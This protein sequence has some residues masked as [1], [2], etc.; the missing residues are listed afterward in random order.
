MVSKKKPIEPDPIPENIYFEDEDYLEPL[1][2]VAEILA[3]VGIS[4][5]SSF[6]EL[7][8][9]AQNISTRLFLNQS[10]VCLK[11]QDDYFMG[12]SA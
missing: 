3:K 5:V 11:R 1:I 10:A 6:D 7:V 4:D 8:A 12:I 9:A 2:N